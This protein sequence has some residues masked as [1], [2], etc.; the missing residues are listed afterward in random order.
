MLFKRSEDPIEDR[1]GIGLIHEELAFHVNLRSSCLA[2]KFVSNC[3]VV[4]ES[5]SPNSDV[6]IGTYR[7]SALMTRCLV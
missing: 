6:L 7:I 1:A 3:P 4:D 5:A 2:C